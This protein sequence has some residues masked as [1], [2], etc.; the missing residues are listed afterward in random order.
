L[1]TTNYTGQLYRLSDSYIL[2]ALDNGTAIEYITPNNAQLSPRGGQ[3]SQQWG[4][5]D[6]T[7][8][9]FVIDTPINPAIPETFVPERRLC[10]L[11]AVDRS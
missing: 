7:N 9:Q 8:P 2:A 3:L 11:A 1:A 6:P 5:V 4:R 10:Q